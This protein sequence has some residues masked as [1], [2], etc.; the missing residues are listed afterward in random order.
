MAGNQTTCAPWFWSMMMGIVSGGV[1]PCIVLYVS[2]DGQV[3]GYVLAIEVRSQTHWDPHHSVRRTSH[4]LGSSSW[5]GVVS[6]TYCLS[7]RLSVCLWGEALLHSDS[8]S[9]SLSLSLSRMMGDAVA[10][11]R[12]AL[13][14]AHE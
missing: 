2:V 1:H 8:L 6:S 7:V 11:W 10:G 12:V 5:L 9:L 4:V 3:G 13:R 14:C